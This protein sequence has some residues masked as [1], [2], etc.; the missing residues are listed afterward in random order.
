MSNE[1]CTFVGI[2]SMPHEKHERKYVTVRWA[3][4]LASGP[5]EWIGTEYYESP[6]CPGE[7]ETVVEQEEW[8]GDC[9]SVLCTVC[10]RELLQSDG[11]MYVD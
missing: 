10:H 11:H 4:G 5:P 6:E 3:C 7:G 8:D 9:A 1:F 2:S